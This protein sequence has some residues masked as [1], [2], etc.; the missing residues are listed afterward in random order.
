MPEAKIDEDRLD[1]WRKQRAKV[2]EAE[3]DERIRKR[4]EARL[5]L[6]AEKRRLQRDTARALLPQEDAIWYLTT[7]ATP[8]FE[9]RV[10]IA[11]TQP[12]DGVAR[13]SATILGQLTG[14]DDLQE[15]FMANEYVHSQAL[16]DQL[17]Y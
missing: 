10:V 1:A 2:A 13:Q 15:V 5:K 17:A 8:L 7:I 14:S 9:A 12:D 6:E 16:M 11:I 3:R 4:D